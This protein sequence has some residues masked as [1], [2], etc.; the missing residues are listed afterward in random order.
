MRVTAE[1]MAA[2]VLL[3][4]TTVMVL[5]ADPDTGMTHKS[6]YRTDIALHYKRAHPV[7]RSSATLD[8]T[9]HHRFESFLTAPAQRCESS[10][11]RR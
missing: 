5:W 6:S 3:R 11:V 4:N 2:I 9:F 1:A 8:F 7:M 10:S